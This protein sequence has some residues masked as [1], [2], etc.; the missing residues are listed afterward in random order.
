MSNYLFIENSPL[1]YKVVCYKNDWEEH[2]IS[3]SGHPIMK[4]NL[5]AVRE[6]IAKPEVIYSSNQWPNRDVYFKR[7]S[8]ATYSD[9]MYTKVIVEQ[10]YEYTEYARV[11]TSWP[12][13]EVK[14]NIDE[15]GLKYVK[16][17]L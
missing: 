15:G 16:P 2:I 6:T 10:P 4:N 3:P 12:Q 11:I 9:K 14:G 7:C 1:G 13:K 5:R 17:K 8:S